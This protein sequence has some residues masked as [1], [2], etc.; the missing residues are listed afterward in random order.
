MDEVAIYLPLRSFY[1]HSSQVAALCEQHG[2]VMRFASDIFGLKT[3]HSRTEEF[4][5]DHH[6]AAYT[7]VRDGWP[8]MVK[9]FLDFDDLARAPC[10][11]VA[12]A[13]RRGRA[14]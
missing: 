14:H 5:G 2:M 10:D 13:S 6:I 12:P 9:R 1:E 7:G 4:E 3:A 8:L 11:V